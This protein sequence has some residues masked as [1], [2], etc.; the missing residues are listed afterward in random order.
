MMYFVKTKLIIGVFLLQSH[1]CVSIYNM[2]QR[3]KSLEEK[4]KNYP[5]LG[6]LLPRDMVKADFLSH[7]APKRLNLVKQYFSF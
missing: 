7:V 5:S 2:C 3:E 4:V 6:I 1:L